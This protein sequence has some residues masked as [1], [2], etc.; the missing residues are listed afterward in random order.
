MTKFRTE[1]SLS[2]VNKQLSYRRNALMIGSCFTENIGNYLQEHYFSVLTNPCGILYNP[3]SIAK[4]IEFILD[5]KQLEPADL[6][7]ANGLWNNFQFHS[8]FSNPDPETALSGMNQSLSLAARKLETASHLFLTFG[9]SWIYREK[10]GNSIVGNCHKLPANRFIRERLSVEEMAEQWI[11]LLNRLFSTHADL[12][13]VFTISPIRHLKD[14]SYQNQVSKSSLF[15]LVDRLLDYFGPEKTT[16]FPSYEL[17]M[18]ELRD[19]RFYATDMLHLSEMATEF[20]QEKFNELYLDPESKEI[21]ILVSKIIK[22]LNH[23]PFHNQDPSYQKMLSKLME[24]AQAL[25]SKYSAVNLNDLI[26]VINQ[27]K[28]L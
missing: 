28:V 12:S 27:K 26:I 24:E 13:V 20:V 14:G 4:S 7:F 16:Y 21:N 8:R 23:K 11:E 2:Q 17:V 9:T 19:Y 6:F 5:G 15:L 18:D 25:V 10:E 22:S 1:I 3:S